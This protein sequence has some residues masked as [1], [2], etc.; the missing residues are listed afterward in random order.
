MLWRDDIV[1]LK[2]CVTDSEEY[3]RQIKPFKSVQVLY[4]DDFLKGKVTEADINIAFEILNYRYHNQSM[5]TIISSE[6]SIEEVLDIDEAVGSRIYERSR[7]Y[8]ITAPA[9]NWRLR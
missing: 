6:R 4:I 3:S 9:E 8:Y 5:R 7:G 1:K 2:A